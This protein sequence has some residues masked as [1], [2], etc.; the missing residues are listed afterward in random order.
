MRRRLLLV[1]LLC[2]PLLRA[3]PCTPQTPVGDDCQLPLVALRPTQANVGQMQVDDEAKALAGKSAEQL[4]RLEHKKQIPVVLGPDGNFY[5][6]DRHHLASAL[7]RIGQT[8][9]TVR[10]I[11]KLDGDFW[12]QMVVRHWAW[13]YDARG[14]AFPPT[15][16]PTSLAALGDDPYRSLAGYA[17]DAGA[18]D[19]A[20]HA[21]FVEFA[22][23]RYF[24]ERMG[25]QT[26]DRGTLPAALKAA[27]QL[28][29]EPAARALPGY[30][31]DCPPGAR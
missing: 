26:I 13:L 18:Y 31:K 2:S 16:L 24:G 11:G 5:L 19:K 3:A 9:A 7:S 6:T 21:Y 29:C 20:R 1:V 10:V 4:E 15:Q 30:R 27:R 28:A 17:Q 14:K 22:W 12:P 8:Q 23:A 25:W